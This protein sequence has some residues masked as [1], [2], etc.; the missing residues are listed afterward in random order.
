[1]GPGGR[2]NARLRARYADRHHFHYR[3]RGPNPWRWPRLTVPHVRPDDRQP[4]GG[5]GGARRRARGDRQ[6]IGAPRP[7]LGAARWWRELR[8]GPLVHLRLHPV[9]T[10]IC[11]PTAWPESATADILGWFRDFI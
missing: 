4:A 8:R 3:R 9:H 7:V 10:V 2:R 5:R 11:G 6:R 1:M